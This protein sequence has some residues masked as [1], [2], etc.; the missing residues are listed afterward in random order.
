M[1][2]AVFDAGGCP[3]GRDHLDLHPAA[4]VGAVAGRL[5]LTG[6]RALR[7]CAGLATTVAIHQKVA[8]RD[9]TGIFRSFRSSRSAVA[10]R[11]S[12]VR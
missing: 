5:Q 4:A 6:G 11:P 8:D 12:V 9:L 3:A 2:V 7:V 1:T 10:G